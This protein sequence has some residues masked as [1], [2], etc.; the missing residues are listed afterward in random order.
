MLLLGGRCSMLDAGYG[1]Q[2]VSNQREGDSGSDTLA[3]PLTPNLALAIL[4]IEAC[5]PTSITRIR[6]PRDKW[7]VS[8]PSLVINECSSQ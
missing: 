7:G 5:G 8:W 2:G 4:N 1:V 3:R 6:L